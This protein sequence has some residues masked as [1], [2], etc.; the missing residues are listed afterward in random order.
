MSVFKSLA[1][2]M[3]L[4]VASSMSHAAT[5][6]DFLYGTSTDGAS[7]PFRYFVPPGYDSTQAYPVILFLH[8]SGERGNNNTAQLNN[9]AN[10]ALQLIGDEQLALQPI[11][12]I[13]PQCPTDGWWGG[14]TLTTAI[15]LVDQIAQSYHI[16]PDRV[17]ITGLSMGG[18][19]TWSAVTAQPARFAAAIPMSGN[20]D[21]SPAPSVAT[22]PFWFFH[23]DNDGT[24]GVA[25]S[26][27]LVAALRDA[28]AS[29]IYTRYD[30]GGHGIWPVAYRHPL[31][32]PW[33]VSQRRGSPSTITPPILRITQ[34]TTAGAFSTDQSII[35][36][37]GI[38]DNDGNTIDSVAWNAVGGGSGNAT[39][40]TSWS[41]ASVALAEGS[42]LIRV[43]ATSPS[44]STNYAGHTTFND[45][46]RVTRT[47]TPPQPG[48][49]VVA[50]NAGGAAYAA[51][52][53]TSFA[54]DTAFDGGSTQVSTHTVNGTADGTLYNSWR[55]GD[56]AY[57]IAVLDGA[58]TVE[59]QFADT[60][61]SGVGQRIF[62]VAIEGATVLNDF[63]II[64]SVGVDTATVRRFDV[65]VSDGMLDL[66]FANG[67]AGSAR[68]DAIRVIRAS[69]DSIFGN[70]F[71]V[72]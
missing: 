45:T 39:G 53:G 20:G 9:N 15:G 51:A 17:Y 40:A 71:E 44:E 64:A 46:L 58:Y 22:L 3:L 62:D 14:A 33:M 59:L 67:S 48:S 42:N 37:S 65:N 26:D 56:F 54:A 69:G 49:V 1:L 10:G 11:F 63:D 25:G 21:S 23:A 41:V 35:D 16:D 30:L 34:P 31:L 7:L 27:A 2:P 61:N 38:A 24:V 29:T 50:I 55:F 68:I 19:G 36:L 13:A 72:E 57:H 32:F 4:M 43:T 52:D 47:G 70:G 12:M 5:P 8:G 66:V 6:A 60:Y 18:I 28:G